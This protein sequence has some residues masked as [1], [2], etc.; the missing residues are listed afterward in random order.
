MFAC[1]F[2][3]IEI[4]KRETY[5]C[6]FLNY[7]QFYASGSRW[8]TCCFSLFCLNLRFWFSN[9]LDKTLQTFNSFTHWLVHC[10]FKKIFKKWSFLAALVSICMFGFFFTLNFCNNL[11]FFVIFQDKDKY[12]LVGLLIIRH[13]TECWLKLLQP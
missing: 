9:Y 7:S 1:V 5:L 12:F 4:I 10:C 11:H 2:T 3:M 6:I 8:L 13:I